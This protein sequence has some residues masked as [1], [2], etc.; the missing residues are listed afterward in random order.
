MVWRSDFHSEQPKVADATIKAQEVITAAQ[1]QRERSLTM[2]CMKVVT[3]WSGFRQV[4][5]L[6]TAYLVE[7]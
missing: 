1:G 2:D 4:F 3:K 5:G 7:H 6:P